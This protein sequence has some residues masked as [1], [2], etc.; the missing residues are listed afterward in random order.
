[1]LVEMIKLLATTNVFGPFEF[2]V[3]V[4]GVK[5]T[6]TKVYEW[7]SFT[8]VAET[9]ELGLVG[10]ATSSIELWT[11]PESEQARYRRVI[12]RLNAFVKGQTQERSTVLDLSTKDLLRFFQRFVD[13]GP[14]TLS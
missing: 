5:L 4:N 2:S 6:I 3:V 10:I 9:K 14:Q 7:H 11:L 8:I 13:I 1:M 12:E